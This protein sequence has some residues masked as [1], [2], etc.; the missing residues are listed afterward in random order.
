MPP[1]IP[2]MISSPMRRRKTPAMAVS[3][4][5]GLEGEM[6]QQGA[7]PNGGPPCI[8]DAP[9]PEI[10]SPLSLDIGRDRASALISSAS[11]LF[12]NIY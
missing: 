4:P 7:G 12:I 9:F 11:P 2:W 1:R 6:V 8:Q 10:G 5:L 3:L